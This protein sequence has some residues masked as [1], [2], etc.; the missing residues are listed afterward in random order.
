MLH[1]ASHW[2]ATMH[3]YSLNFF[4]KI[5]K[6]IEFTTACQKCKK[7]FGSL[8][9]LEINSLRQDLMVGFQKK[10]KKVQLI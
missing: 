5:N 9:P 1:E 10:K 7:S 4:E 8:G 2:K 3:I 6:I